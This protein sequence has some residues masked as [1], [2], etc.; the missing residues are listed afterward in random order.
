SDIP[1]SGAAVY[2]QEPGAVA[3]IAP[4][5]RAGSKYSRTAMI[6]AARAE[7]LAPNAPN[8]AARMA[9]VAIDST[10][11]DATGFF[12]FTAVTIPTDGKV[13]VSV[14]KDGYASYQELVT[15]GGGANASVDAALAEAAVTSAAGVESNPVTIAVNGTSSANAKMDLSIPAGSILDASGNPVT[16]DVKVEVAVA[17]PSIDADRSVFPGSFAAATPGQDLNEAPE[18]LESVAFAEIT[19]R[20]A[21]T[22]E[23]YTTLDETAPATVKFKLPQDI[24]DGTTLNPDTGVAYVAG[25]TIPW[26]SYNED[27]GVWEQEDADPATPAVLDDAT[28][29][30]GADGLYVEAK[31]VHFTWWN[32]DYPLTRAYLNIHIVNDAGQPVPG[33]QVRAEGVSYNT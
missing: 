13:L 32:G 27:L 11:T 18:T 10:T 23:E 3:R 25:D 6:N 5:P 12:S 24:Q 28:V 16:G 9:R 20:D 29:V 4:L 21:V 1:I 30:S 26:W 2:I 15:L 31:V 22:G 33:V 14:E 7:I 17:D 8:R 19:I